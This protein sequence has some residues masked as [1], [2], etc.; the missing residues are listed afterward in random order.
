MDLHYGLISTDDHVQE[1]PTVWTDRLS[2]PRWGDR[3]PQIR[4]LPDGSERWFVDDTALDIP[5]VSLA[6]GLLPNRN[7]EPQRWDE[8]PAAAF[9]PAA[10]LL[11]MD[12]DRIDG[13]VLYPTVAGIAGEIFARIAEPELE[14]AC[15]QAYN[16][17]L[18]EEWATTSNR[19][20]PQ[21]II[22]L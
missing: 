11:A 7:R 14:L 22:P 13:S 15:V 8:L 9:D 16:D 17:W 1:L 10:R 4:R 3:I 6:A 19:F 2:R 21:C 20:V 5:G 18:V 12:V